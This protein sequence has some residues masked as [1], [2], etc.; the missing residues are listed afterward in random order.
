MCK[1]DG[2]SWHT[3][4][5]VWW[6]GNLE[7]SSLLVGQ[8]LDG[9]SGPVHLVDFLPCQRGQGLGKG[10]ERFGIRLLSVL[11]ASHGMKKSAPFDHI[12]SPLPMV[13]NNSD[14]LA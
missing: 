10:G 12:E 13:R 8:A 6:L 14:Y 9:N 5:I 4:Y 1:R 2:N 7:F 3:F 11:C